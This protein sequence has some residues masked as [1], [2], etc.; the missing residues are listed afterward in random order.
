[1]SLRERL[2]KTGT[3]GAVAILVVAPLLDR[4]VFRSLWLANY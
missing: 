2:I 1:M 3:V 4:V